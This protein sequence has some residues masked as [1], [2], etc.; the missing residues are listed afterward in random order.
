MRPAKYIA[1]CII[2]FNFF[3]GLYA[4]EKNKVPAAVTSIFDDLH[5]DDPAKNSVLLPGEDSIQ[6]IKK[7]IFIEAVISKNH[8][9]VGEPILLTY[10]LFSALQSTSKISKAAS[11]AGFSVGAMEPDNE[12]V[13]RKKI[14]GREYR[15]FII[16]QV[17]LVPLQEG[18]IIIDPISVYNEV[19][20]KEGQKEFH[21]SGNVDVKAIKISID[22]LPVDGRPA[23]FEGATGIFAIHARSDTIVAAG[24]ND[25]LHIEIAGSGNFTAISLPDIKWPAGC[26]H[27][28]VS[29][30]LEVD[31][32]LFP[33]S[34]KKIMDIP[35]VVA[36]EGDLVIAAIRMSFFDTKKKNYQLAY[37]D[38][39]KIH[40]SAAIHKQLPVEPVAVT[41]KQFPSANLLVGGI[42]LILILIAIILYN[43]KRNKRSI[44]V[45]PPISQ[46]T[47][48][49]LKVQ[50]EI[51][52]KDQL[53]S[54]DVYIDSKEYATAF[55]KLM[56]KN[57]QQQTDLLNAN[58]ESLV[59]AI[60]TKDT[61]LATSAGHL[62]A[63]CNNLLYAPDNLSVAGKMQMENEL[64]DLSA[65]VNKIFY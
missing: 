25:T 59:M 30:H 2:C 21:Y 53:N 1:V 18:V 44:S 38:A 51:I 34:G 8:C 6:K 10:T 33:P 36:K 46:A 5:I 28:S 62:F 48:V 13:N 61:K 40:V 64:A 27:F 39:I 22:A 65:G 49:I 14:N 63:Q 32:N 57:L 37:S 55:K 29:N 47:P 9:F 56:M 15:V 54:L 17:Q 3:P 26:E 60:Q 4:Q 7:N 24:E 41:K 16:Q 20:Y 11:F 50:K 43:K 31:K 19:S 12:Q 45:K 58:E 42:I 35:F 52:G 23:D